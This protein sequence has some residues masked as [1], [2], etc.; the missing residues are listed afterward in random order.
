MSTPK[1]K[2][3][4]PAV[5]HSK[6]S[7]APQLQSIQSIN[8]SSSSPNILDSSLDDNS[9][10]ARSRKSI[11]NIPDLVVNPAT[12]VTELE[13]CTEVPLLLNGLDQFQDRSKQQTQSSTQGFTTNAKSLLNVKPTPSSQPQ[14]PT[15][16]RTL[17]R[18]PTGFES[19]SQLNTHLQQDVIDFTRLLDEDLM[20]RE[21]GHHHHAD[22]VIM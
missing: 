8:P 19:L 22:S 2:R 9:V 7:T 16:S 12:S 15:Q 20:V 6:H 11:I 13:S 14:S 4:E 5:V 10:T 21:L 17:F 18:N 1:R 3:R